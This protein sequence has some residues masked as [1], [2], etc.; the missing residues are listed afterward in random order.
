MLLVLGYNV[1]VLSMII[2]NIYDD[3]E[4]ICVYDNI[5]NHERNFFDDRKHSIKVINELPDFAERAVLGVY[6]PRTKQSVLSELLIPEN[7]TFINLIHPSVQISYTT[8]LMRGILINVN[9]CIAGHSVIGNF[10]TINRAVSIGHHT[11]IDDHVTI[12][13]GVTI[14]GKVHIMEGATIGAGATI[15]DGVTIGKNAVVGAGAVVVSDV[16]E[17]DKVFGVPAKVKI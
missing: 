13:P 12:N 3:S 15:I 17:S 16:Y 9:T 14:C 10:V 2:D 5:N 1:N 8:R 4:E 11:I 6:R 7:I